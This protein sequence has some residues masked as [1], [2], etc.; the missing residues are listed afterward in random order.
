MNTSPHFEQ[1]PYKSFKRPSLKTV[2]KLTAQIGISGGKAM[3]FVLLI[4]STVNFGLVIYALVRL[5]TTQF[6]WSHAGIFTL[7]ILLA[8]GFTVLAGYLTY[9]YIILLGIQKVYDATLEQRTKI[10]ED[11]IRRMEN[12]FS[13]K[14][15]LSQAQLHQAVDWTKTVYRYY[16]AVPVF[17]Q[18]GITQYFNR[19]PITNY[20][21]DLKEDILA[22]DHRTA[23]VKFRISIDEFFEEHVIGSPTNIWT[24]LL[25]PINILV[26]YG[27]ITWGMTVYS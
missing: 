9:R 15:E 6:S 27:L 10:S 12:I 20:I 21:I 22:R 18:S 25:L 16:Q 14:E 23:A 7:A 2:L 24:W 1:T 26:L 17:F 13:G 4:F 11:I 8:I 3:L 19:I 5:F